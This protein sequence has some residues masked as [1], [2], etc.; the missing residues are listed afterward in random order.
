MQAVLACHAEMVDAVWLWLSAT[1]S[2]DGAADE[3]SSAAHSALQAQVACARV[4]HALA[5]L[6]FGP[7]KVM[8]AAP[9]C[10]DGAWA[11]ALPPPGMA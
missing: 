3:R 10:F 11:A 6:S 2:T 4:A 8:H 1:P 5:E 7:V 9:A